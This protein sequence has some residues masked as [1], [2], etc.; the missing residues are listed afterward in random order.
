MATFTTVNDLVVDMGNGVHN[1]SSDQLTVALCNAANPPAA[2]DGQL[3]DITQIAY[4]NLSARNLTTTSWSQSGGIAKLVLADLTLTASGAVAPFRYAVIYNN[5]ATNDELIGYLDY[6]SEITMADTET[7]KL[8]FNA[9][10]GGL[11]IGPGT[12]T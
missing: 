1:L 3:S 10:N 6:G 4:T 11:Q 9:T 8:D 12:I 2:T 5:D 7:F